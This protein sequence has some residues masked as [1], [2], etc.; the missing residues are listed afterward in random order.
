MP[1]TTGYILNLKTCLL[2]MSFLKH[3]QQRWR[4]KELVQI[5]LL[6]DVR[7]GDAEAHPIELNIAANHV[8]PTETQTE[9]S[10]LRAQVS[11]YQEVLVTAEQKE[12]LIMA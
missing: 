12:D 5:E 6:D 4:R 10:R 3:C 11:R 2:G 9:V 8:E 1:V 7:M